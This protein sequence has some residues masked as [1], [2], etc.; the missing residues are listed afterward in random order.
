MNTKF[1][2]KYFSFFRCFIFFFFVICIVSSFHTLVFAASADQKIYDDA[3]LFSN[4]E[5]KLLEQ[6]YATSS[7][8][9]GI[10]IILI[11]SDDTKGKSSKVFLEDFFDEAYAANAIKKD[12][13]LFLIN[14]EA[15]N[16]TIQGYGSCE[17]SISDDRIEYILDDITP[18]MSDG[19]YVETASLFAKEAEYYAGETNKRSYYGGKQPFYL[20][21]WFLAIVAV[22]IGGITIC[23]MTVNAGGK[24]TTTS[25]TYLNADSPGVISHHDHFMYTSVTKVKRESSDSGGRSSGGGGTSSGGSSHSG[26]SRDF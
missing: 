6:A 10:D 16:L 7:Q 9:A 5:E 20:K 17:V 14:M 21:P 8:N 12:T 2:T 11:T 23:I 22:V 3:N 26:G 24:V 18:M 15:R 1:Q 13:V 25:N 4:K 19:N